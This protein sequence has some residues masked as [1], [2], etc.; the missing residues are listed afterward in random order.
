MGSENNMDEVDKMIE[1]L[2]NEIMAKKFDYMNRRRKKE[3]NL[4][5][6]FD[7][8]AILEEEFYSISKMQTAYKKYQKVSGVTSASHSQEL[9]EKIKALQSNMGTV[10]SQIPKE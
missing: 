10:V 3:L 4:Q 8:I 7:E 1:T 6:A 2:Y 5:T 9:A